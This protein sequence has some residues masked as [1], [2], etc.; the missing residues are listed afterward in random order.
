MLEGTRQGSSLGDRVLV[1]AGEG[2]RH[3]DYPPV[4]WLGFDLFDSESP[5]RLGGR[6]NRP[7]PAVT[8]N[9]LPSAFS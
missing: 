3:R 4:E 7:L 9:D 5:Q 8:A 2:Q 1:C 6:L